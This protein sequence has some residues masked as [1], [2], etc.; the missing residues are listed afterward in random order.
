[1]LVAYI[2]RPTDRFCVES[3]VTSCSCITSQKDSLLFSGRGVERPKSG[4]GVLPRTL[5]I[6]RAV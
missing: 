4:S 3:F 1:M 5:S 6:I 2:W